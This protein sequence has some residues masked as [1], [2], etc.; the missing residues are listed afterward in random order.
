MQH[1]WVSGRGTSIKFNAACGPRRTRN[2]VAVSTLVQVV[3]LR[4][5]NLRLISRKRV[6]GL[7]Y[8]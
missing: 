1:L 5:A 3:C 2:G 6:R 7:D 4:L 8:A